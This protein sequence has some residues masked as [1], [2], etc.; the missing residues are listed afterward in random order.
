MPKAPDVP[1][2]LNVAEF[3]FKVM[4][5]GTGD[6]AA[7]E[8]RGTLTRN[9]L[10]DLDVTVQMAREWRDFY[11]NEIIRNPKN[12]SARGRIDLMQRA[13]EL[14]EATDA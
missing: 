13:I 7:R 6:E 8:R 3:G 2:G 14:L 12:P 9:E 10:V 5:W 1:K 11:R 4:R